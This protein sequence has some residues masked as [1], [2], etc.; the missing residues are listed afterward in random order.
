V[1]ALLQL[2]GEPSR[3][4]PLGVGAG[5]AAADRAQVVEQHTCII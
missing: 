3:R 4:A 2:V 5:A 1:A